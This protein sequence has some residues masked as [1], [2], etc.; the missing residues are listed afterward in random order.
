MCI[1]DRDEHMSSLGGSIKGARCSLP[2]KLKRTSRIVEKTFCQGTC[3]RIFDVV[4]CMIVVDDMSIAA[5][6]LSRLAAESEVE[7]VR[8]KER[9]IREPT[10]GG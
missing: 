9:F 6:A 4:R 8:I 1:R 5:E 2:D 10:S 7:I 3:S